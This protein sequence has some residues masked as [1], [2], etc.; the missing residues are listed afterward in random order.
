ML[1]KR[2]AMEQARVETVIAGAR[3][4]VSQ[5]ANFFRA[6]VPYGLIS[7]RDIEPPQQRE[8]HSLTR[9]CQLTRRVEAGFE[10]D[11]AKKRG[12]IRRWRVGARRNGDRFG[13]GF[14]GDGDGR[15][16]EAT[17]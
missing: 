14:A 2:G 9:Y 10:L 16:D 4:C 15:K 11:I 17:D 1:A 7:V 8:M 5:A 3:H 12:D 13:I 6:I